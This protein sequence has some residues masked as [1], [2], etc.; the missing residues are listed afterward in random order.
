MIGHENLI[1][2]FKK[3]AENNRL[4][5][6]YLFFGEPQVGKFLFASS[7]ANY[8]ENKIFAVP[9]VPLKE[10][11]MLEIKK[12]EDEK[13]SVGID[14]IRS[15]QNF[16][17]QKPVFSPKRTVIIRDAKDL[18]SEAQ[19]AIL[20]ILEE[21][22]P[23]SLIIFIASGYDNLFP[24]VVSRLQK[25]YFPRMRTEEIADFLKKNLRLSEIK[26]KSIAEES[27]GR[28][29]RAIA[30][31]QN[32]KSKIKNQNFK[33]EDIIENN[34]IDEYFEFLIADLYK[35]PVKNYKK[36]KQALN[37]LTLMGEFNLNKKLQ[38]K[39]LWSKIS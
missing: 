7:L 3:L 34:Q 36:L 31:A 15:L 14:E 21:P 27:F 9:R 10:T 38:L 37:T 13:E 2:D 23:E 6:A 29:G 30:I 25:I 22:P 4:S 17:Y 28:P 11:L 33:I 20:K 5:H 32:Q 18:T 39:N 24:T 8:L 12:G 35:E 16:L 26:S 19:N 1:K